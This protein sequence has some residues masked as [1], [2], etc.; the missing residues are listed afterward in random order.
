MAKDIN[1]EIFSDE[2]LLKLDIFAECF[3]EWFPVFIHDNFTKGI[4][5]IDFFAGSG[6]DAKNNLGSPLLLLKEAKGENCKYCNE[7]FKNDKKVYF[8]FNENKKQKH[9]E[10]QDNVK[11]F[12]NQCNQENCRKN[13]CVY[14]YN[15]IDR[16]DF[17]EMFYENT[18]FT[19]ILPDKDI[20]KF[21]LLDQYGFKEV[22]EDVFIKLVNSPHTD[23][24][25]FISSSFIK[26]FKE[27]E[28]TK[29]YIDTEN[30]PFDESNV[31]ECHRLIADYYQKLIPQEKEYYIHH[32]TIKKSSSYLGLIF[33]TNHSLGMEKFLKVCWKHD[34]YSGESNFNIDDDYPK[35]SL[36]Y[37]EKT[38]NKKE[39][40]KTV[41]KNKII[42]GEISDNIN[43]IKFTLKNR[44]QPDVFISIVQ[45]MEKS[46]LISCSPKMNRQSTNIHKADKYFIE[47]LKQ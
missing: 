25:F 27:H 6:K 15:N 26:R 2:T 14:S 41:I 45:E 47:V 35:G 8:A 21:I 3:R 22:D 29:K 19:K 28:H 16:Y 39:K 24:I 11:Y 12:I 34:P 10:L 33:G 42:S 36:F 17:K 44:C 37:D 7:V 40:V 30:I 9:S 18:I 43:G 46:K 31:K 5:I 32:F 23:F 1:K 13:G 20:A 4:F 38:T